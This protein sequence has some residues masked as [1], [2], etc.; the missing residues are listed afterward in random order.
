MQ[1]VCHNCMA[2]ANRAV[3]VF[4][5]E[6]Y[7]DHSKTVYSPFTKILFSKKKKK[8]KLIYNFFQLI[9]SDHNVL[10]QKLWGKPINQNLDYLCLSWA[11]AAKA[12]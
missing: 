8:M 10:N 2:T 3:V 5:K 7:L 1:N 6:F 9:F 12:V 11:A 4:V